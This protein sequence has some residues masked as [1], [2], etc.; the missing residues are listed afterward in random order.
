MKPESKSFLVFTIAGIIAG[1]ISFYLKNNL[2]SLLFAI[3]A[4]VAIAEGLKKVLKSNEK[5]KWFL[6]NGG[7]IY[8]FIWFITWIILFTVIK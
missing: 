4:L 7:L 3:I 2:F 5:F 8:I 1:V 6:T